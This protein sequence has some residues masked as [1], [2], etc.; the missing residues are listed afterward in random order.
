[1]TILEVC[2]ENWQER[3]RHWMSLYS[4]LTNTV[5]GGGVDQIKVI[6]DETRKRLRE[7]NSGINHSKEHK[8]ALKESAKRLRIQIDGKEYES[9]IAASRALEIPVGTIGNRIKSKYFTNYLVV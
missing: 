1:M 6:S 7:I 5:A 3:E 8:D 9:L 2:T 4:D